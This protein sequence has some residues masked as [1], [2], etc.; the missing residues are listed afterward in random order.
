MKRQL[1]GALVIGVICV[2]LGWSLKPGTVRTETRTVEVTKE[3]KKESEDVQEEVRVIERPDGTKETITNRTAKRVTETDVSKEKEKNK[4]R[5]ESGQPHRW[6]IGGYVS[7]T[8]GDN[9]YLLSV[10]RR[11]LGNVFVGVY[12]QASSI[13]DYSAGAGLRFEF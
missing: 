11:L 8:G 7:A 4:S 13:T 12:V 6:S 5:T 3:T 9:A 2:G 1:I 10:D